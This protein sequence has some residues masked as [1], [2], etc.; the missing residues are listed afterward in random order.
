MALPGAA[1]GARFSTL[2]PQPARVVESAYI[3]D[4]TP[5]YSAPV[6]WGANRSPFIS[7]FEGERI[8]ES[9]YLSYAPGVLSVSP[10][11]TFSSSGNQGGPFSPVSQAFTLTN[12]GK[13]PLGW[14]GQVT[15]S[16]LT[17]NQASGNLDVGASTTVTA[18]ISS[19][20]NTLSAGSYIGAIGFE[21]ASTLDE[22][23]SISSNLTVNS[24]P[25]M[26]VLNDVAVGTP[27]N[28]GT[29]PIGSGWGGGNTAIFTAS[30]TGD[31]Y[32][33][34]LS[35]D[36]GVTWQ[37]ASTFLSP[38]LTI[39]DNVLTSMGETYSSPL[40]NGTKFRCTT[41]IGVNSYTSNAGTFVCPN[42]AIAGNTG[43]QNQIVTLGS[44][45]YI[46]AACDGTWSPGTPLAGTTFQWMRWNLGTGSYDVVN[47]GG[48][49]SGATTPILTITGITTVEATHYVPP[50]PAFV[51]NQWT[52]FVC[53][54]SF[55][56]VRGWSWSAPR[57]YLVYL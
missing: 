1:P 54:V 24:P 8:I 26:N 18:S 23:F 3:A 7:V 48:V 20:A 46:T 11:T 31:S 17:L 47:N 30:L 44:N 52:H 49:Y 41:T 13:S 19:A 37:D 55:G 36:G 35:Q 51:Q 14:I 50:P 25:P 4:T 40:G 39:V 27:L 22:T 43:V 42:D 34:E 56:S 5:V 45:T 33:W 15:E 32:Y 2:Y 12:I 57:A 38:S 9:G 6:S 53:F 28:D 10:L 21:N 29:S 16:W